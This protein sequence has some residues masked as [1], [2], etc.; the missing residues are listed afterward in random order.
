MRA[1]NLSENNH[2]RKTQSNVTIKLFSV[3]LVISASFIWSNLMYSQS[4]E[5]MEKKLAG[6]FEVESTKVIFTKVIEVDGVSATDLY[7]RILPFFS[8][9]YKNKES[10]IQIED[11]NNLYIVSMGI[12][13]NIANGFNIIFD[14]S[15]YSNAEHVLRIDF[16]EGKLRVMITVDKIQE[17]TSTGYSAEYWLCIMFPFVPQEKEK[18]LS[19]DEKKELKVSYAVYNEVNYTF[20]AIEKFAKTDM[21][22]AKEW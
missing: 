5:E 20:T 14:Y 15:Y 11:K 4:Y 16:K 6:T 1:T 9:N 2:C 22:T 12:F 3:L 19:S 8:Y 10:S 17:Y 18:K 21:K 7:E 13:K